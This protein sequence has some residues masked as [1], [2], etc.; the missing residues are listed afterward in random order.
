M[1]KVLFNNKILN[2]LLCHICLPELPS[3]LLNPPFLNLYFT[4]ITICGRFYQW[5]L[6]VF[7]NVPLSD[8]VKDLYLRNIKARLNSNNNCGL[9]CTLVIVLDTDTNDLAEDISKPRTRFMAKK[10]PGFCT[11]Y[12]YLINYCEVDVLRIWRYL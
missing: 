1:A 8:Q 7:S 6:F 5:T 2:I 9:W 3:P 4:H 12:T 11:T 10:C